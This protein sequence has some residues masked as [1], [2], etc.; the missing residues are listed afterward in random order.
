MVRPKTKTALMETSQQNFH[1]LIQLLSEIPEEKRVEFFCFDVEKE[2]GAHWK[3]DR[4][5]RDVL[6]HLYEWHQLLV[7]W[8]V[9]NQAG[10]Q[11]P[12]LLE[13]YNWR[14]YGEM[15]LVFWEKHQ[16]TTYDQAVTLLETSHK[17]VMI[18]VETFTDEELFTKK[19]Y[20]WVGGSSLGSYF[21]SATTS[22]Y[23][24][25]IKKIR[26][27]QKMIKNQVSG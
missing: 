5:I 6:T 13:G 10:M 22:H 7:D 17:Q 19:N 21:I 20:P 3:R 2:K 11:R 1:I 24:W 23:E 8:V 27:H 16:Q 25:A 12:F 18:L 26:K 15:N 9:A 14:T 4:N